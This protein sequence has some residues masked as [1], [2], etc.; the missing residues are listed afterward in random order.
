VRPIAV[1]LI[2]FVS[3]AGC[4][5]STDPFIGFGG[6]GGA[7]TAAQAT[8]NW[9]FT[10]QRT[11]NLPCT[12]ALAS[13]QLI[14]GHLDVQSDGTV[15]STSS[16]Q[17]PLSGSVNQLTGTVSLTNGAIDLTFRATV[18]SA[19]E[20]FPGTMSSSGTISGATLTDPAAGSSQV[21]GSNGCQYT[22]TATKTS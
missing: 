5:N 14:T 9:S 12:Q 21:F 3:V 18:G 15:A 22:V 17:N 2:L 4:E 20:L 7:L 19:L 11:T 6:G 13:G 8:G 16:W 1:C 10:V